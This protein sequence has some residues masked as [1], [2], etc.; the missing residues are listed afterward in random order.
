M[1]EIMPK[2]FIGSLEDC[3]TNKGN[4]DLFVVHACKEPCHRNFVGYSGKA[5]QKDHPL[6]LSGGNSFNLYLNLVDP[7]KFEFIPQGIVRE[8]VDTIHF[9][10]CKGQ[11]VLVHCNEGKSR[12]PSIIFL[13]MLK[14]GKL[15]VNKLPMML[16]EFCVLYPTYNPRSGFMGFI[17]NNLEEY[18]YG[19]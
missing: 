2:L 3:K 7:D 4:E 19:K 8:A 11:S 18:I 12:A 17:K 13:Y 14:Y 1:F 6:Y 9:H 5:C 16:N 10:L 15:K